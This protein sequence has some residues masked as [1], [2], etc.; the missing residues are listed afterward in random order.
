MSKGAWVTL[1]TISTRNYSQARGAKMGYSQAQGP[2]PLTTNQ[3][4]IS[5]VEGKNLEVRWGPEK[6]QQVWQTTSGDHVLG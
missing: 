4:N 5:V 6:S 3:D 2:H 1:L